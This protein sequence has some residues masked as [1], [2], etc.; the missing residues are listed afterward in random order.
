MIDR[1]GLLSKKEGKEEKWKEREEKRRK[2]AGKTPRTWGS[3]RKK[4]KVRHRF[5]LFV[6]GS[7]SALGE[8][9]RFPYSGG[10]GGFVIMSLI[11]FVMSVGVKDGRWKDER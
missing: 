4:R 11:F 7:S 2:P 10:G 5:F 3:Q 8:I 6:S 9:M 1:E